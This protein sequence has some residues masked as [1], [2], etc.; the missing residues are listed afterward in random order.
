[1]LAAIGD[2][3]GSARSPRAV[4]GASISAI[5]KC[6]HATGR[7]RSRTP[8]LATRRPSFRPRPTVSPALGVRATL[9]SNPQQAPKQHC[10]AASIESLPADPPPLVGSN[11]GQIPVDV[12]RRE[13]LAS[14]RGHQEAISPGGTESKP[15]S[16]LQCWNRIHGPAEATIAFRPIEAAGSTLEARRGWLTGIVL[17]QDVLGGVLERGE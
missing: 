9:Q 10:P 3:R 11:R 2:W 15:R 12:R 5:P 4:F 7:P 13:C 1:M 6:Q 16:P 14:R 8:R 17:E